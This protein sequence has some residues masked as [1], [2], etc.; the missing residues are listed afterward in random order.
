M[1]T[2]K[3]S[4]KLFKFHRQWRFFLVYS[5]M[6]KCRTFSQ[7][8]QNFP[9]SPPPDIHTHTH[10]HTHTLTNYLKRV[11]SKK[12]GFLFYFYIRVVM[13][14]DGFECKIYC[15]IGQLFTISNL[16]GDEI[17]HSTTSSIFP[18]FESR[19][20]CRIDD[21]CFFIFFYLLWFFMPLNVFY[22]FSI[23]PSIIFQLW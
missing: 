10:K 14:F 13:V 22:L 21:G 15:F 17:R 5:L 16:L 8:L 11:Y 6:I 18:S 4:S 9:L 3:T 19:Y 23:H 1:V 7:K 20:H 12:Y 2:E